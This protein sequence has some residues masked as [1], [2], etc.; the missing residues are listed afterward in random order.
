[1]C[2]KPA[3]QIQNNK[4]NVTKEDIDSTKKWGKS[5][6]KFLGAVI[7]ETRQKNSPDTTFRVIQELKH[8]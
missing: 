7:K 2:K 1:M 5:Q 8:V 3:I 6:D 4:I